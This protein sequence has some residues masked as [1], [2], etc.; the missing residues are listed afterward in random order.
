MSSAVVDLKE[1]QLELLYDQYL[2]LILV[3]NFRTQ[4]IAAM[5]ARKRLFDQVRSHPHRS[6]RFCYTD[7]RAQL[8]QINLEA[9]IHLDSLSTLREEESF[10][11]GQMSLKQL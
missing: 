1:R 6:I 2:V 8:S 3:I 4:K 5:R 9:V 7:I 11:R 10:H